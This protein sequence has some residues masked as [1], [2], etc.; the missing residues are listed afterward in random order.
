MV[1]TPARESDHPA[2]NAVVGAGERDRSA[3]SLRM[4]GDV[5]R[6]LDGIAAG[7]R[8]ED[9]GVTSKVSRQYALEFAKEVD[10]CLRRE[11]Q[12]MPDCLGLGFERGHEARVTVPEIEDTDASHPVN[13]PV[14]VHVLDRSSLGDL[15]CDGEVVRVADRVGFESR[16]LREQLPRSRTGGRNDDAWGVREAEP[17]ALRGHEPLPPTECPPF[18]NKTRPTPLSGESHP[19]RSRP[20]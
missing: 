11:L 1:A 4:V 20:R 2:M 3:L 8:E 14:S 10:A 5:D 9:P 7:N 12:G 6:R 16:L 17:V 15:R 13:E 18:P 19:P